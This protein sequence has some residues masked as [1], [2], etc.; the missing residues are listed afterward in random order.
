MKKDFVHFLLSDMTL[1]YHSLGSKTNQKR[2]Y[3]FLISIPQFKLVAHIYNWYI[4]LSVL[5]V[6]AS[7]GLIGA[8]QVNVDTIF[9]PDD[10]VVNSISKRQVNNILNL[11]YQIPDR[12]V[13]NRHTIANQRNQLPVA[14][15]R[16][17]PPSTQS[18]LINYNF[19]P[20]TDF[21]WSIF[22]VSSGQTVTL[23]HSKC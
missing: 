19:D 14:P 15:T 3:V 17:P 10:R 7:S 6:L 8:D 13:D 18:Q 2:K 23:E 16:N 21:V 4:F 9:F 5:L 11:V 20:I 12:I 22:K 1:L